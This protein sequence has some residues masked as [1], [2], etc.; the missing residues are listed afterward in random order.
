MVHRLRGGLDN[1]AVSGEVDDSTSSRE[2][3]GRKLWLP[4]GVSDKLRG[5]GFAIAAQWFIYR[6]TT[7]AMG[8][9]DISRPVATED[10]NSDG[11]L[12]SLAH[13]YYDPYIYIYIAPF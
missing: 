11:Q 10:H 6:G 4:D 12:P 5:L 2:I 3:F 8:T 7:L 13:C 1:G 9:G